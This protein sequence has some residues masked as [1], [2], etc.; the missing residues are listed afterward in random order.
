MGSC[1]VGVYWGA[2]KESKEECA[3]RLKAFLRVLAQQSGGLAHW[4]KKTSSRKAAAKAAPIDCDTVE[5]L[6][7][8]HRR[9]IGGDV[10]TELGFSFEAWTGFD[11][12]TVASLAMKCG[13]YSQVV[14]NYLVISFADSHNL[15]EN[16]EEILQTAVSTFDP[17]HGVVNL[18]ESP[19]AEVEPRVLFKYKK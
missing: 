15:P 18:R 5:S 16:L 1:L 14:G 6:L 17:D 4:F 7:K 11:T 19:N 12:K 9:D 10:I 2:R 8:A 3:Q 13:S